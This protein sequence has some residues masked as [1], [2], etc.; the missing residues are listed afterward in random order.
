VS[1]A[2][3]DLGRTLRRLIHSGQSIIC[4][5]HVLEKNMGDLVDIVQ[6]RCCAKFLFLGVDLWESL[7]WGM[8]RTLRT[9]GCPVCED[10]PLRRP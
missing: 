6:V 9:R 10:G 8:C 7:V 2:L 3:C 4:R 5:P 1:T